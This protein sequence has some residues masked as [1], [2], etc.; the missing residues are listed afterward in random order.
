MTVSE[1]IMPRRMTQKQKP[2][3]SKYLSIL[4]VIL[5]VCCTFDRVHG[6]DVSHPVPHHVKE[7]MTVKREVS[8]KPT[9]AFTRLESIAAIG[10][11]LLGDSSQQEAD[12]E[13][14][15]AISPQA[16]HGPPT[17]RDGKRKQMRKAVGR[18]IQTV[19]KTRNKTADVRFRTTSRG[20]RDLERD[21]NMWQTEGGSA[22][23][24]ML[25]G[26]GQEQPEEQE[27]DQQDLEIEA[28]QN[29]Y[30]DEAEQLEAQDPGQKQGLFT[31][32]V[33]I[34]RA[35][36]LG[37]GGFLD[38]FG[39]FA[40]DVA[41]GVQ[42]AADNPFVAGAVVAG[43]VGTVMGV[44]GLA[45]ILCAT[46]TICPDSPTAAPILPISTSAI[47]T[48]LLPGEIT[49]VPNDV[50]TAVAAIVEFYSGVLRA[51]FP[52]SF[53]SFTIENFSST[54]RPNG[55]DT[56]NLINY[57]AVSFFTTSV[58]SAEPSKLQNRRGDPLKRVK[59]L[60]GDEGGLSRDADV[61]KEKKQGRLGRIIGANATQANGTLANGT[62]EANETLADEDVILD[63]EDTVIIMRQDTLQ[64]QVDRTIE[65]ANTTEFTELLR[66]RAAEAAEESIYE[67]AIS[68]DSESTTSKAPTRAP[69]SSPTPMDDTPN[70][71]PMGA[72]PNPTPM[73]DTPNPTPMDDTPN[74][75]PMG[76]TPN[77][78]PM[79]DTPNPTPMDDTPNPTT[80]DPTTA[81][82]PTAN[83]T[84]EKP[85]EEGLPQETVFAA[86]PES[87]ILV[88]EPELGFNF[89]SPD[90][91]E[92]LSGIAHS[93]QDK[94][95]TVVEEND[96]K[97]DPET[98][99]KLQ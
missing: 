74:P 19:P 9:K 66:T 7:T 54:V 63:L 88:R 99:R 28:G 5:L 41:K 94:D 3:S 29:A 4:V 1:M 53:V 12:E 69:T 6:N 22:L 10:A 78:T 56:D 37:R 35:G 75:T 17:T 98:R 62:Q 58:A 13:N 26:L 39:D 87:E 81:D 27:Q 84:T 21:A 44:G 50:N 32:E 40:S 86:F 85:T 18:K 60:K 65:D 8:P 92:S 61:T 95:Y 2:V 34:Q 70:P 97:D 89:G 64:A 83:P 49:N 15:D 51:A 80:A 31:D 90:D 68:A 46:G 52:D 11:Y 42:K 55:D 59:G 36:G 14:D 24:T 23:Q 72:T 43:A 57:R 48:I 91:Q 73:D 77:P 79:D 25:R 82:P 38:G 33:N 93:L 16:K 71:T 76:A 20:R 47:L 67:N 45:L 96:F 30:I